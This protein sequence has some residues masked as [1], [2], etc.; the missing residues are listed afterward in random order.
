MCTDHAGLSVA[1]FRWRQSAG[2]AP[3]FIYPDPLFNG[4]ARDDPSNSNNIDLVTAPLPTTV[5]EDTWLVRLDHKFNENTLFTVAPNATSA[6]WMPPTAA[7]C[8]KINCKP[9]TILRITCSRLEHTFTPRLFN[10]AKFYVNRSP[11]HNPASKCAALCREH[12]N[13]FV[14]L[15]DN[16]ADIEVGTTYGLLDNLIWTRGRHAFKTRHGVFVAFVSIKVKLPTT[17]SA[18]AST[19]DMIDC[20]TVEHHIHRSV[21]LPPA[22]TQCSSCHTSR[23]N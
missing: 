14:G 16:T 19:D 18:F 13:A 3:R 1:S 22:A 2:C 23:M 6:W 10:E 7:A 9:S 11:F 5:H 8:R 4:R 12:R 21:V 17:P 15:N 20:D